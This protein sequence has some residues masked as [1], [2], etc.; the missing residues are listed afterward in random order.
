MSKI[1]S[2]V[3]LSISNA[4]FFAYHGVKQEEKNL[5]G[6]YQ[7]DVDLVYDSTQAVLSDDV[8]VAL[9]Y[10]EAMF[11]LSE[12]MNDEDSYNLV[13]TVVYEILN[14]IFEK[15]PQVLEATCR[16]RKMNV[17]IRQVVDYIE[18]EQTMQRD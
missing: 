1:V 12:V 5:G 8:N 17:P 10:E 18:V 9:N 6:Q 15:F 7:I 2:P 14:A 11:C 16:V 13:E 4:Q 3:R